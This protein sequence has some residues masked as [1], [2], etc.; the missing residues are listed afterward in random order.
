MPFPPATLLA[1]SSFRAAVVAPAWRLSLTPL[2]PLLP[3]LAPVHLAPLPRSSTRHLNPA[4]RSPFGSPYNLG[5]SLQDRE[6]LTTPGYPR[7]GAISRH[8]LRGGRSCSCL[9]VPASSS[10]LRLCSAWFP[11]W[12]PGTAGRR[13]KPRPRPPVPACRPSPP[14]LPPRQRKG[15]EGRDSAWPSPLCSLS[16]AP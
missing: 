11:A 15:P 6:Q 9:Q 3:P 2:P 8:L 14:K 10:S 4:A 13:E 16:T 5:E 12:S 1:N 7:S